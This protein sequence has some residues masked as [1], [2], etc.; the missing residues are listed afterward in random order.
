MSN[1]IRG[2]AAETSVC[3]LEQR[4]ALKRAARLKTTP[5]SAKGHIVAAWSGN[6]APRRAIKAFCLECVGFD[7]QA[8][9]GCAAYA[10]PLWCFR[11]FQQKAAT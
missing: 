7:R 6:C 2:T 5:E 9:A 8:I 4:I 10:C 1:A 11:P 3:D